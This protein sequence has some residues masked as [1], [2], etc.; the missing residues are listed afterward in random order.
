MD[1]VGFGFGDFDA[2]GAVYDGL[3]DN[4]QPID[5]SGQFV[6]T[7]ADGPSDLDGPFHGPVDMMAKLAA[8]AQVTE[9]TTLQQFRYALGRP[10][11]DADACS[12]Q[13]IYR[14]FSASDFNLQALIIAIVRSDAFR[15]RKVSTSGACR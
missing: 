1:L 7:S 6:A 12:A 4:G 11:A 14:D 9:C 8:S 15:T 13:A 10:E 3:L 2:T 5:D